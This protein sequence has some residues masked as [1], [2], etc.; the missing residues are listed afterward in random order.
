MHNFVHLFD[1]E[2]FCL[3][4]RFQI[5][6]PSTN[7]CCWRKLY[8]LSLCLMKV[9]LS[10]S[11]NLDVIL[12]M[13]HLICMGLIPALTVQWTWLSKLLALSHFKNNFLTFFTIIHPLSIS[14]HSQYHKLK[15]FG[16]V[17]VKKKPSFKSA[18]C[19]MLNCCAH[20]FRWLGCEW[21]DSQIQAT[22]W[23][24]GSKTYSSDITWCREKTGTFLVGCNAESKHL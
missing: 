23:N 6:L 8:Q 11:S 10:V 15:T 24:V 9:G 1:T 22:R 2:N 20:L 19:I 17:T 3:S 7:Q 13:P 12:G 14:F 4:A 5:E 21:S 18:M 16:T